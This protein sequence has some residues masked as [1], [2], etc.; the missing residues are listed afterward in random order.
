MKSGVLKWIAALVVLLLIGAALFLQKERKI[1][2]LNDITKEGRLVALIETGE[3]GFTSDSSKVRG[4]QYEIIRRYADY[5]GVELLLIHSDN[6]GDAYSGLN[7][8]NFDVLV[9]LRPVSTD[10]TGFVSSL[11]PV[12][13]TRLMLVQK[14]DSMGKLPVQYQY[15]LDNQMVH[16]QKATPFIHRLKL[17]ADEV[18]A[19]IDIVET[20]SE[21][22]DELV[23]KVYKAEISFTICPEYLAAKLISKYPETDIS[24]PLSFN[25]D[26]SWM[27]HTE[28]VE[29]RNSLNTFL[30]EF[31]GSPEF[32]NLYQQYFLVK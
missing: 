24:L 19:D 7:K 14:K 4:F 17:L 28:S 1:R 32:S 29:L 6:I 16:V 23:S 11:I 25:E 8:G 5:L 27:V 26:L 30:A 22:L 9:S 12:L 31:V 2:D 15:Q 10:T 3:Y 13:S 18:A 20:D 21:S